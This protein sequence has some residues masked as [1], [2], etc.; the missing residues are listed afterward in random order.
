[1]KELGRQLLAAGSGMIRLNYETRAEWEGALD[2]GDHHLGT[3]RMH[4]DPKQ[5]VV[6]AN[7]RVHG[8][9]N[10]YVAGSG[11]F[12]TYSASNPTMNLVALALRLAQHLKGALR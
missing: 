1:M 2:W 9:S 10:L 7:S 8:M 11:I 4:A 6:D 5:G 12:P 3:T